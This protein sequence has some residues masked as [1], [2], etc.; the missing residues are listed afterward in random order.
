MFFGMRKRGRADGPGGCAVPVLRKHHPESRRR[1]ATT[2]PAGGRIAQAAAALGALL[3]LAGCSDRVLDTGLTFGYV[4]DSV[5][6]ESPPPPAA[7]TPSPVRPL[8]DNNPAYP[9]LSSVPMRPDPPSTPAQ[10]QRTIER[11]QIDEQLRQLAPPLPVPPA[12]DAATQARK[13]R[14][15]TG[16]AP[17]GG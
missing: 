6:N 12:P 13:A 16:A 8:S 2:G 15:G 14:A 10:R 4:R 7:A 1:P 3:A 17:P 9:P 11:H 5:L